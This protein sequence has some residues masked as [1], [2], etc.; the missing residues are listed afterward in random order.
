MKKLI[1][2]EKNSVALRIAIILS[3][4]KFRRERKGGLS[5]FRFSS[6]D[7]YTV[8]G[9]R[10]HIVELDFPERYNRWESVDP[11]ELIYVEPEKR[12]L[13][14]SMVDALVSEAR[15]ADEIIIAT[16][17]DR[18][19]E[20]IG[21][22]TLD[23]LLPGERQQNHQVRRARFSSLN[24]A[25]VIRA[26]EQLH[27]VDLRLAR[28]AECRQVIDLAWGATLTRLIS[29]A[30][31]QRGRNFLSVGRVQSPT[32]ALIAQREMEIEN[33]VPEN[34]YDIVATGRK[35]IEFPLSHENNPFWKKEEAEAVMARVAGAKE[36]T[37]SLY[38]EEEKRE[39]GPVPFSTTLFL[40]DATRLGYSGAEAMQ[41]AESLYA[42]GLISYPRTD[43]T[44]YPRTLSLKGVLE[45]LLQSDFAQEARELLSLERLSPTRGSVETTDHP[46]IYPVE[47]ASRKKV[48]K[49]AWPIYELVVRR[50]LATIAPDCVYT[51]RKAQ[52]L[53]KGEP[54]TAEGYKIREEG[55]RRYYPY[56]RF[57]E[58]ELPSLEKGELI[59]ILSTS[60]EEKQTRPPARYTQGSLI[61]EMER[62]GLGTKSTRHEIIQKLVERKYI[63][64]QPVRPTPLGMSVSLALRQ[65]APEVCDNRM[66]AQLERDMDKIAEGEK[67]M[68]EVVDESR[69]MLLAV[70]NEVEANRE[71]IGHTI[72][73]ALKRQKL[74]GN[75]SRCGGELYIREDGNAARVRCSNYPE[76]SV[77]FVLPS[78]HLIKPTKETCGTC[79]LPMVRLIAKG[80]SPLDVCIDP[81]CE[82][83][84]KK[85]TLGTC[86]KCGRQ[87]R[88]VR[89]ARGKRFIG[90]EGY[91]ECNVTYPL[92]QKGEVHT[93]GQACTVC[94]APVVEIGMG[95]KGRWRLCVNMECPS[96]KTAAVA[97]K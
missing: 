49:R 69:Q 78:G 71:E 58:E 41:I 90:C 13:Y 86:P 94:G 84:S 38:T 27:D 33:F 79:G 59:E 81:S 42:S 9:L 18:E 48:S 45:K 52:V 7:E 1:I 39:R 73:E 88:I 19:G 77:D 74:L 10:G 51:E 6:V 87:L 61:R 67:E 85:G 53:V 64:G 68:R 46:P 8:I 28:S 62:L 96:K 75:C 24:R 82:T 76:C 29:L 21:V 72:R 50:F 26:F 32:L 56:Y 3:S 93:T 55:W 95:K 92:P 22:E 63:E 65:R 54:F 23:L 34:Y 43:N 16:D 66:T 31:G 40:V 60:M 15:N 5:I 57:R 97:G 44:V 83:N 25:E 11:K 70:A 17:F 2:S 14:H 37:V 80:K 30:A 89:S 36:G 35:G 20:L 12:V 91:P 4:G 47:A